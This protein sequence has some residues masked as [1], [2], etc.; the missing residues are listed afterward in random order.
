[1]RM[2]RLMMTAR[3][4]KSQVWCQWSWAFL[5]C[6]RQALQIGSPLV[7]SSHTHTHVIW[8][9]AGTRGEGG[10][11]GGGGGCIGRR[12]LE[13]R[14][15]E[16]RERGRKKAQVTGERERERVQPQEDEEGGGGGGEG[17]AGGGGGGRDG[18]GI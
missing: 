1:M 16:G 15:E 8:S 4:K 3:K 6:W 12:N 13:G 5:V 14:R 2:E 18:G 11:G 7:A 10:R 9:L 17:G